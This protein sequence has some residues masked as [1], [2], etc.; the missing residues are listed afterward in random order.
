MIG[1]TIVAFGTSMPELTVSIQAAMS[2]S[3]D[4]AA[5]NVVGSNIFNIALI[6]GLAAVICP[7]RITAQ[8]FR[9]DIPILIGVSL[10]GIVVL[11]DRRLS[12]PEGLLL[13][14]GIVGYTLLSYYLAYKKPDAA[15][16][17]ETEE[18]LNQQKTPAAQRN[19]WLS[20]GSVLLG[21]GLLVIGSK[22]L[23]SGAVRLAQVFG[24]SEAVIGLTIVSAGTSLPELAT[25]VVAAFRKQP[26][27]AVGNVVGSNI[28]NILAILGISSVLVPYSAPGIRIG[29]P[30]DYAG[31]SSNFLANDVEPVYSVPTGRGNT[32]N[33][34]WFLHGYLWLK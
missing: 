28:F 23:V 11:R 10:L 17:K 24:L 1:L 13:V 21:L 22:A 2:G 32:I 18:M 27:I 16:I 14:A 26:D 7:I 20:V 25:S 33:V 19:L 15:L 4:I 31:G 3:G 9:M 6:F 30:A 8:L 29:G 34:L 12:R 5:A